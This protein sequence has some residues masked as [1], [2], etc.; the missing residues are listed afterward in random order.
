MSK[1]GKLFLFAVVILSLSSY[2]FAGNPAPIVAIT[3]PVNN[4]I[5]N[6]NSIAVTVSFSATANDK[7]DKPTGSVK[8]IILKLDTITVATYNNPSAVKQGMKT[9]TLDISKIAEGPHILQAYGYQGDISAGLEGKSDSVTF[10]IERTPDTPQIS[11]QSGFIHGIV[12]DSNTNSP[13]NGATVTIDE[14]TG[15]ALTNEQGKFSFPT[16]GTGDFKLTCHKTGYTIAQRKTSVVTTRNTAVDDIYLKPMDTAITTITNAGGI[17]TSANGK[18]IVTIP[19]NALPIGTSSINVQATLYEH[20]RELPA[21]LPK[22]SFFTYCL[23]LEPDGTQFTQL[24]DIKFANA[25]GF[26]PGTQIPIGLYNAK[27]FQ[28]EDSGQMST[29]SADGQ[30]VEFQMN[31]FS[32]PDCNFPFAW[33]APQEC[34]SAVTTQTSDSNDNSKV[35]AKDS[36][37]SL[38]R[39]KTGELSMDHSFPSIKAF[40]QDFSLTFF[41]NSYSANPMSLIATDTNLNSI[42]TTMPAYTSFKLSIEGLNSST[43]FKA[44]AGSTRQAYLFPCTDPNN[45]KL[46]TGSYPYTLEI[47]N[48]YSATYGTA[49]YFGGPPT[50]NTGVNTID[51]ISMTSASKGR[52]VVNNQQ[53][54]PFGSGWSLNGLQRLYFDPDGTLLLTE[55]DGSAKTFKKPQGKCIAVLDNAAPNGVSVLINNGDGTLRSPGITSLIEASGPYSVISADFNRDGITDLAR[56]NSGSYLVSIL[57]GIGDGGFKAPV[58][59]SGGDA[60]N[61]ALRQIV[62]ADFN[63]DSFI[64]LAVTNSNNVVSILLNNG[65]GTLAA[66]VF[67]AVGKYP[68]SSVCVDINHDDKIDLVVVDY[69][70]KIY[71]LFGNGN[72]TFQSPIVHTASIGYSGSGDVVNSGDFNGDGETDLVLARSTYWSGEIVILLGNGDGTFQE[73]LFA[74]R[75]DPRSMAVADFNKDGFDDF[76]IVHVLSYGNWDGFYVYLSNGDGTFKNEVLYLVGSFPYLVIASDFNDDSIID[77]A[78]G[79]TNY[80]ASSVNVFLGKGDGTFHSPQGYLAGSAWASNNICVFDIIADSSIAEADLLPPAGD[81]S[82]LKKNP[83]NTY[84]RR[85]KDGTKINFNQQGMQTQTIDRNGNIIAFEYQ[86][87]DG[88]GIPAE[89]S[90]ITLSTGQQ[91]HFAYSSGK[92]LSVTDPANRVTKFNIDYQGNLIQITNADNTNRYFTYDTNHLLTKKTDERGHTAEYFYDQAGAIREV[93]SPQR[94]VTEVAA[95]G[96]TTTSSQVETRKY[97][98]SNKQGLINDLPSGVGTEQDPAPAVATNGI[99]EKMIDG[100]GNVWTYRTDKFGG[101]LA[102]IDPL[103]NTTSYRRDENSNA[104]QIIQPNISSTETYY[105][106][107]GNLTF[108]ADCYNYS[109]SRYRTTKITYEPNFNQP[110]SI[111]DPLK[112]TTLIEYDAKGNPIKIT[113]AKG[114]ISTMEYNTR[115]QVTKVISAFGTTLQNQTIFAY[116]PVT[117]NLISITDPLNHSTS[118]TYSNAGNVEKITDANNKSTQFTYDLMNRV[119]TATDADNKTTIYAYDNIGNLVSVTDAN[120]HTTTFTYDEQNQLVK[121]TNPLNEQKLVSYDI[122]RNLSMIVTPKGAQIKLYNNAVNLVTKK[123]LPEG[124]V[125]YTYN[126]QYNLT[127]TTNADSDLTF[128]YDTL[129]RLTQAQTAG[130]VQPATSISYAYDLNSNLI[131]MVNPAG[132]ITKYVY[133]TLNRLTDI[134][135]PANQVISHYDYDALSRRTGKSFAVSGLP[136]AVN[137]TY[138]IASQLLAISHMPLAISANYSY[139]NVGNRLS[140]T[141]NNGLH[142]YSYDNVYRLLNSTNPNEAYNYDPVGNRNP[143][144]QTY[145]SGN[146]LLEDDTYTYTYDLD[147]N[148]VSKVKKAGGETTTYNYNS[149]DQLIGVTTPIQTISYKYDSLGRRIEKNVS[150]TITRYIYDGE[151]IIQELDQNNQITATYTHGPGIDEPICLEKNSQKYY[152]I[153]DGLGSITTLVDQNGNIAQT[154]R[155]DSFGNIISQNGSLTQPYTYTG[156]EYDQETGLYY[157][158]HRY[159]DPKMGRFLQ[160]DPIWNTNLYGYCYSNP[161][162][163]VDP[164]GLFSGKDFGIGVLKGAGYLAGGVVIGAGLVVAAPIIGATTAT[165]ALTGMAIYGSASLGWTAGQAIVGE[166]ISWENGGF[167]KQGMCDAERSEMLG[168]TAVGI[169]ALGFAKVKIKNTTIDSSSGP[170]GPHLHYGNNIPGS[171]HPMIHFGP[172]A[173]KGGSGSWDGWINWASKGGGWKWK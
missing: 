147:G 5:T 94:A 112:N 4:Y 107:K 153:S 138:D 116:D 14:V 16:P 62:P 69:F 10:I 125:D 146:R 48:F 42:Y 71:T 84:T 101:R 8:T 91:Y 57:F 144:T 170:L 82:S 124:V 55:G 100:K 163:L 137:Y 149:E 60:S 145:D 21:P 63:G 65:D 22:T 38:V 61:G 130:I 32:W 104:L 53:A 2:A 12:Y 7:K 143:I 154:Y 142:N 132:I 23:D 51:P 128:T 158:R 139:D 102:F 140:L 93:H 164:Y 97:Y 3:Q 165:V 28:W 135:N 168:E 72:G 67:Y 99:V 30:W 17:H 13:L 35:C 79:Y 70:R 73:Q 15:T 121:T 54:S 6:Q 126:N 26:A 122:N 9:F 49:N 160:E 80:D 120:N 92:L 66:P 46:P 36:G 43:Y 11:P 151:D 40:N 117:F 86:D 159:Y 58:D 31:H 25:L 98:P 148:M 41:Y 119:K 173:P 171:N 78:A 45:D 127:R 103:G 111:T 162:N 157:Y 39:L 96:T 129:S 108:I 76:A 44:K 75:N 64:D 167:V 155:Y 37:N 88:D 106:A 50:G 110:V 136:F 29:V 89:P 20:S 161:L 27:T 118:F 131:S 152:Y 134:K 113:D 18:I 56:L 105:D 123:F 90:V 52:I 150:G 87:A 81:F 47:S 59:Y 24:V 172:K 33:P 141:D 77:L 156:R 95:D 74:G 68:L 114:A 133:D 166:K 83:D 109:W 19:P 169:A 85:M 34:A 115:G 1:L